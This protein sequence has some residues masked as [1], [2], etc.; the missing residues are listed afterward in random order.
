MNFQGL[1]DAQIMMKHLIFLSLLP[2]LLLGQ[3]GPPPLPGQEQS[4]STIDPRDLFIQ[5]ISENNLS[6]PDEVPVDVPAV[7]DFNPG[8]F[9]G[10]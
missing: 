1:K 4:S 7:P 2:G 5:S 8:M 3:N 6:I 9:I 10:S